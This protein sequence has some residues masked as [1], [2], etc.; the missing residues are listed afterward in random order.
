MGLM[1]GLFKGAML[2]KAIGMFTNRRRRARY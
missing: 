2:K 1:S